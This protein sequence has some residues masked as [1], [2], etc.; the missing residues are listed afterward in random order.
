MT[1]VFE[2]ERDRLFAIAYRML[3][4]VADAED[5]LQ[6]VW[7]AW[8][9]VDHPEVA[10]P[11]AYLARMTT[12]RCLDTLRAARR[13]RE[14][15]VGP[16]L[17]EPLL[18]TGDADDDD[19]ELADSVRIA[20]LVAL[21]SLSPAERAALVLRDAFGYPYDEL[22]G[23]LDR[24]ET[25]CRQVVARARRHVQA[26]RPRQSANP[27]HADEVAARFL[28]AARH[29]DLDG[30]LAVLHPDAELVS[31]GGG[32]ASAARRTVTGADP[33]A[34]F[35]AGI[36]AR[37][38]DAEYRPVLVNAAPGAIMTT[39]EGPTV[40]SIDIDGER[41]TRIHVIR[42]PDKLTHVHPS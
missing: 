40:I 16:W 20:F 34:R 24:S 36:A 6:D 30:L 7:L 11:A 5:V 8:Q 25:A 2:A 3:G 19:A 21:E 38:P 9:P 14:A 12:N 42:N 39:A 18:A 17:P 31:D 10:R 37:Q 29:G 26:R 22:A 41:V 4:S 1:G 32:K 23:I 13:H 33:V 15:Y 27:A 35:V 28:A